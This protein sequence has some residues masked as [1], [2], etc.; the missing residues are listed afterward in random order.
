MLG[1]SDRV[2]NALKYALALV[3]VLAACNGSP[4]SG[5]DGLV[6]GTGRVTLDDA[7]PSY[8]SIRYDDRGF[9]VDGEYRLL[10]GGSVQW[11]R[12]P[13]ETWDDRL[14]RFRAA[15]FNTVD[16]YVPWNV[17]EP[18]PG[19]FV[20][21][22]P[23][24][25]RF[26]ELCK[27]HG[28]YVYLRPGPYITNEMDGGGVP[29]W[30][31]TTTTKKQK[32][33]DG[34]PNLRTSDPDYLALVDRYL[35]ALDQVIKPYLI[36]N[37]GPI[38]LY[39]IENEYDW[40][41]IFH[42]V[43]KLFW[44]GGGPE[45][46]V[47]ETTGTAAY[48]T[49]LRDIVRGDGIDVP[50]TTCPGSG[51]VAG[52]GDV[53]GII[54]MPNIYTRG[55]TER[56]AYDIVTAMHDPTKFGGAYVGMPSGSTETERTAARLERLV[57]GGLDGVFAF[58]VVGMHTD[59]YRNAVV[60]DNAGPRSIFELSTDRILDAFVS[61]TVGYFHNVIDYYGAIGPSGTLR[62]KFWSFRRTNMMLDAFEPWIAAVRHP[63]RS[64]E[65]VDGGDGRLRVHHP[66]LGALED[67]KRVFYWLDA[68]DGARFVGLTNET[69]VAQTLAP[70]AIE[71]DGMRIPART[72]MTV[73]GEDY[74][75]APGSVESENVHILVAGA[76]LG[77]GNVR[78]GY[79][80]S[81][82]LSVRELD[83][84]RLLVVHGVTGSEGE[85]VLDGLGTGFQV[86]LADGVT[87]ADATA[88]RLLVTYTH[89]TG[90]TLVVRTAAGDTLQVLI[91][92]REDAGRTWFFEVD[93]KDLVVIGPDLARPGANGGLAI[94]Y[95]SGASGTEHLVTLSAAPLSL[96]GVTVDE[97]WRAGSRVTRWSRTTG[98]PPTIAVDLRH[99]QLGPDDRGETGIVTTDAS[100]T[101]WTGEPRPLE[102]LGIFGGHAWYRTR[103]RIEGNPAERS[104]G[105][106]LWLEHASDFV[107]IYVNGHY[108][109]T[110]APLGTE[111]DNRSWTPAY[112]FPDVTPYLVRGENVIAFRVEVWGHGSFMWPRGDL[113]PSRARLPSLGFDSV[114]G[115][116]GRAELGGEALTQW[117]ARA[118]LG[119]ERAG[120]YAPAAS[121]QWPS[122]A[123][124]TTLERGAITWYRVR[125]DPAALPDPARFHAP[126]VV[127]LRGKDVKATIWLDGRLVGRWLS[128]DGWLGRGS[129]AR[130]RRDMWMTMS[131]DE[132]P[133]DVESLR[134]DGT[135]VLVFAF[136][137]VSGTGSSGGR[138]DTLELAAAAEE[139]TDA[140]GVDVPI[141]TP[142]R[143]ETLEL[144][145]QP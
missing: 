92:T 79:T 94:D 125:I 17:I 128:D 96:A 36:S 45:R 85:L 110:V 21:D 66:S 37:G 56:T 137:D 73:P 39:G 119:G 22:Q 84:R 112:A 51:K 29:A 46:N 61:P 87:V 99:G 118:E 74:P 12:L 75:G 105:W 2:T 145:I 72:T 132:F 113:L 93:G 101:A 67:G 31:F 35:G 102:Q 62:A 19:T 1:Y 139:R 115:L 43:D 48:M 90:S 124:P 134:R 108:V 138:I 14:A 121:A 78:L 131:P 5:T 15:G 98:T 42:E 13:P 8:T 95:E 24:L 59:G 142:T 55:R 3:V 69:G 117:S 9:I 109:T 91:T 129:W 11:F 25:R 32:D 143:R 33:P 57:L 82:V 38:V 26:L 104:G 127:R 20:F 71:L 27:A 130:G 47:F 63:Q 28:L 80:T 44:Y 111:I 140:S 4:A 60:L 120:W 52:T 76:P 122:A 40:F 54:P 123:L 136:E 50:I 106:K 86:V 53:P 141:A 6:P 116:W 10:R 41:E 30:V 77:V 100:W 133:I 70:G 83:D 103:V 49:A 88:G 23:D 16:M 18:T 126:M 68:G 65:G 81:E 34:A 135:D 107:G 114:K 97:P 64:G 144:T 7:A 89:R 58:N